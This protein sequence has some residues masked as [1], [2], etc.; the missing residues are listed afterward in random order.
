MANVGTAPAG[1]T[2]IGAG[3]TSSP[4]FASIGTDS[5]LTA[6]G[7]VIAEGTSAFAVAAPGPSGTILV[8]N[9][10]GSDP[11]F[12][13]GGTIFANTITGDSGGAL[14]PSAGNWNLLGTANQISTSGAGATLTFSVPSAFIGPGSI[15]STT[16][17]TAGTGLT[18]TT[19][20]AAVSAGNITVPNTNAGL[21]EG[22]IS[23][24]DGTRLH[25][26]G[27]T[28][29][30]FFGRLSGNGTMTGTANVGISTSA[31]AGVTSGNN[32]IAIGVNAGQLIQ[33]GGDN[34][35]IGVSALTTATS[36]GSNTAVGRNALRL[37][38]S[39]TNNTAH[40][41]EALRNVLGSSNTA[42]GYQAGTNYASTEANNI[43][44]GAGV[45]G[46]STESN[47][48]R[49]GASQN[50]CYIDGID[51][52]N[53]G[54]VAKVLT[55][56]SDQLGTATITAGSNITVTPGANT[57]TIAATGNIS[58]TEVTGTSQSAAVNNGYIANNAGLVTITLPAS[59]AV[60]DTIRIS[61]LGAGGW[62]LVANTGDII[63]FG[64]S[65]TSA[66]GSLS[67]TNRYDAVE[68]LGV[69]TNSTWVVLSSIGNLTVA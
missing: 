52:V 35:A 6:H 8:S 46:T 45:N 47:V 27:S 39:G 50:A 65:P 18:V 49:I 68:I 17:M 28:N 59:F 12:Q 63:N 54:S 24:A 66:G 62:S 10:A 36:A 15:T 31:L 11:T 2:L 23:W 37:L 44:I 33:G 48:T 42:I 34:I 5:G 3:N 9:G 38:V 30:V 58:W 67:S 1:R 32:N 25:N 51:G 26:F 56:A 60:G 64:S 16:T 57:I 21:T 20:N 13:T 29:N 19:G 14:S 69:A 55:M 61:G 53:V 4:R 40:G 22:V 41:Y 43:C 7:V